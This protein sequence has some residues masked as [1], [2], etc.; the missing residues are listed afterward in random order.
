MYRFAFNQVKRIIPK[1]S[2]TEIIALKSGGVSID[3]EI[4]QGKVDYKKLYKRPNALKESNTWRETN[5]LLA[6][7][8]QANVYPCDN[9][10]SLMKF[11]GQ[12]GY[13]GMIIDKKYIPA[14]SSKPGL[15]TTV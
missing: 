13:L 15:N 11:L 6:R 12:Q 8:G 1:I 4:F 2:E 5:E 7:V 3:R 14:I 9:I 10:H